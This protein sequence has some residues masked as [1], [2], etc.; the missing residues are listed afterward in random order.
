V[1]LIAQKE[2][3][4]FFK[5]WAFRFFSPFFFGSIHFFFLF[6]FYMLAFF[7]QTKPYCLL[8]VLMWS[9]LLYICS[10]WVF[11]LAALLL[12]QIS[13]FVLLD[14]MFQHVLGISVRCWIRYSNIL[15][16]RSFDLHL[17]TFIFLRHYFLLGYRNY[18]TT[19]SS[20]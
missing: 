7:I 20:K 15:Y 3:F 2:L 1:F 8:R 6:C 12:K 9:P 11:V 17:R 5:S 14:T 19:C 18:S 16:A 10:C 4:F 13:L